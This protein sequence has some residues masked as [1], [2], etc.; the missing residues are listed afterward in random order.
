MYTRQV[1]HVILGRVL[2]TIV[3]WKT[4]G[5]TYSG[6]VS[7]DVFVQHAKRMPHIIL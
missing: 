2:V 5:I 6:C 1:M 7:V 3:A 4:I